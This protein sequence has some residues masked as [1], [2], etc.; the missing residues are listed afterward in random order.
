MMKR[1]K[2]KRD[3]R[4]PIGSSLLMPW[5]VPW[6]VRRRRVKM[7][8]EIDLLREQLA[9]ILN[10]ASE[11][12]DYASPSMPSYMLVRRELIDALASKVR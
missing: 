8:H 5:I 4:P 10:S 9:L 7:Q 3:R 2:I 11:W 1:M 12:P 6:C